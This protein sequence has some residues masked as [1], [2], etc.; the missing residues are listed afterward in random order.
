MIFLVNLLSCLS[1][2]GV[3][4]VITLYYLSAFFFLSQFLIFSFTLLGLNCIIII[5]KSIYIYIYILGKK[6]EWNI[7]FIV[8]KEQDN[9]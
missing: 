7:L 8:I 4:Y 1:I 6:I 9:D 2:V 3:S 5:K